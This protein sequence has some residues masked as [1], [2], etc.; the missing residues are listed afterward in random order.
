MKG[1]IKGCFF[2][3]LKLFSLVDDD[4]RLSFLPSRWND[5]ESNISCSFRDLRSD[6]QFLDVTLCCEDGDK[7]ISAHKVVLAA[8]SAFFRRVLAH[9]GHAVGN[10]NP[11]LYLSGVD[12]D[13]LTAVLNFMYQGEVNVSQEELSAFL[14]VAEL[15]QV[16]GLTDGDKK[17]G[18][19]DEG[20]ESQPDQQRGS[21]SASGPAVLKRPT[22]A[23]A[24][25]KTEL[26]KAQQHSSQSKPPP[27]LQ[28]GAPSKKRK[29][30]LPAVPSATPGPSSS[31]FSQPSVMKNEVSL[32]D[33]DDDVV[34][35]EEEDYG[36]VQA[37]AE[38]GEEEGGA[39]GSFG[40]FDYL[41]QGEAGTGEIDPQLTADGKG[42]P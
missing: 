11:V 21:G 36:Q 6:R 7:K 32:V 18:N 42:K 40:Q 33:D 27:L 9:C 3:Q 1:L 19:G 12:Y 25:S 20:G 17:N 10:T 22:A 28:A 38:G 29:L 14:K 8:C 35:E 39:F 41:G 23:S 34:V 5:F 26:K 4:E 30:E 2:S 15:L 31:S 24:Q 13:N 16:K 37:A